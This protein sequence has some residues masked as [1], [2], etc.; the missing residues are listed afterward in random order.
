MKKV[1]LWVCG[2]LGY[3][4]VWKFNLS[5]IYGQAKNLREFALQF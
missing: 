2:V 3:L 4:L 5:Y 1:G